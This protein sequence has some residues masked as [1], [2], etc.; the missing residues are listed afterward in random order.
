MMLE[1]NPLVPNLFEI[2]VAFA[3][4]V[5]IACVVLYLILR[6]VVWAPQ[7][8]KMLEAVRKHAFWTGVI[9]WALSSLAGANQAGTFPA[10]QMQLSPNPWAVVPFFWII[11]PVAAVLVVHLVGQLSWPAP[12][13]PTRMA[14]LEFRRIRDFVQPT[15]GWTVLGVFLLSAGVLVWLAFAPGF[16][17]REAWSP[18]EGTWHGPLNG[19]VPGWVLATA[20]GTALVV[21][22]LGT[23]FVM[24]LIASRR[25]IEGLDSTQN[26]TLRTIGMNRLLRVAATV[27]SGLAA[28]AGNFLGQSGPDVEASSWVNWL[29]LLNIVVSIAM[30]LWKPALLDSPTDDAGYNVLF[31]TWASPDLTSGDGPAAARFTNSARAAVFP[32]AIV[33]AAV[34]YATHGWF[35]LMGIVALSAVFALLAILGL[36]FVLRRKYATP[37]TPRSKVRVLL[38]RPMYFAFAIAAVGLVLALINAHSVAKS[39]SP[40]SWD[41]LAA[42]EAMYWVPGIAALAILAS[43]LSAAWFVL[44]RPGLS[45]APATLDRTLRRRSLFRVARTVTG[46]WYAIL[47]ILLI[48]I[49]VAPDPNPLMSGFESGIFG[50]LCLVIAALVSFYP[51]RGFTPADFMPAAKHNTSLSN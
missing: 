45:N 44:A 34:G 30:L 38:P 46:S 49:P 48:M 14:V 5:A 4:V 13:S 21:L 36:E 39:G 27:A 12:K 11:G 24:A 8:D 28:I 32:A 40:N 16:P 2:L 31:A 18:K 6:F 26:K 35:G 10:S 7:R 50:A 33:G 15:L 9:A 1:P 22:A 29:G 42:P 41:G 17:A 47:G 43:A 20:L 37:G 3:P 19:R 25:S 23:L 51:M